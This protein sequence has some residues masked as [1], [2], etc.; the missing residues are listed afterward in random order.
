MEGGGDMV[1]DEVLII[2]K[3]L[4]ASI[5]EQRWVKSSLVNGDGLAR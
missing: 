1:A 5:A 4:R 3:A 2:T